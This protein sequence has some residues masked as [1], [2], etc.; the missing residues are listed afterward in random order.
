MIE[1]YKKGEISI[2]ASPDGIHWETTNGPYWNYQDAFAFFESMPKV[3]GL[4]YRISV[5]APKS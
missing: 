1:A 3:D 4:K 5:E 2:W